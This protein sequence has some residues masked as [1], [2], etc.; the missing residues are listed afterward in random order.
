[1]NNP[2]ITDPDMEEAM[3]RVR[4]RP[5]GLVQCMSRGIVCFC[6]VAQLSG[7]AAHDSN[8]FIGHDSFDTDQGS[9]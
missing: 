6:G 3:E 2:N 5:L 8:L 9:Q 4:M 1:M 7:T